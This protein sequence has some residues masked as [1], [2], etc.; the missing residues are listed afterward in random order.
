[1]SKN[2]VF[3]TAVTVK[4]Q[5]S[6]SNPYQYAIKTWQAWCDKN[7]ARLIVCNE[8]LFPIEE[9][10]INFHRYYAFDVL[11]YNE[12]EYDQILITDADCIIHPDT[13]NFFE[14][15]DNR[16]T[17]VRCIGDVDWMIRG[18]ENY[19]KFLFNGRMF[20]FTKRY[21]N[22][23]FQI[24]NKNHRSLWSDMMKFYFDNKD[25]II[26]LQ[27]QFG[28]GVDQVL[29]NMIVNL[30]L[31]DDDMMYLPYE[32]CATHL[33]RL[34]ILNNLIFLECFPGIYQFNGIPNNSDASLTEYYMRETYNK[35]ITKGLLT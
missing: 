33:H 29:V 25:T 16:Y 11:D 2:I 30:E 24:V 27:N 6:R 9:L 23:G 31:T 34:E 7:N 12:I 28:T 19:S 4:G 1:M 18:I 21:F 5:E 20:D 32:Y 13:P 14:M 15:T 3:M 17:V 22:A 26:T 35:L 8:L 10:R